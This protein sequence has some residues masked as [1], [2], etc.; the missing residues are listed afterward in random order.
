[1]KYVYLIRS[2][3]YPDQTYTGMTSDVQKRLTAHNTGKSPHTSKYRPWELVTCIGF[4]CEE[5]ASQFERY[6][7]TG[8]GRAFAAK[9][10]W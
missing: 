6:L 7:K 1:M 9:R 10:L 2:A 4:S 5:K 3:T 8:S